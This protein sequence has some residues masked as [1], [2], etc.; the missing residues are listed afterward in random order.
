MSFDA[1]IVAFGI[2]TL[3]Q[4]LQLVPGYSAYLVL[5]SVIILDSWLMY[6]FFSSLPAPVADPPVAN[7]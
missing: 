5:A 4:Q 3:L 1:W 2:S 7:Q 6:Q